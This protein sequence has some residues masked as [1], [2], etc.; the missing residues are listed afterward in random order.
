MAKHT[1][2]V[3]SSIAAVPVA[4]GL[5]AP[6]TN[7]ATGTA[8]GHTTRHV[9]RTT[10]APKEF[11][12]PMANLK[13]WTEAVVVTMNNVRIEGHSPVHPLNN[14]CEMHFGAH[15]TAFQG[16]PDGLVLEPMNVCVQPFPGQSA[17]NNSDWT[18]FGDQLVNATIS[19]TGV[20]RIWPEHLQGG[21]A[22][23]PDHAVEMHPLTAIANGSAN[24]DFTDNIFAG[25]YGGG[26]G[27]ATAFSILDT[28][29]VDVT[30]SG[31]ALTVSFFGGTIGNFTVLDVQIDRASITGDG[32]G[33][34]RMT[35]DVVTNDTTVPVR[36]VS[37][38]GTAMN[39]AIGKL[40]STS[41]A[42]V[43]LQALV[44]FSLSPEALLDAANKS[45]G[46]AQSVQTPIQLILY[47]T[48]D[49]K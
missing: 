14:D 45:N 20:P 32:A 31:A 18:T 28:A 22:S 26:V 47:G 8:A 30:R 42:K 1:R 44:L 33:S 34:F 11:S 3:T 24:T 23:N 4:L 35:G 15:S 41:S 40:R 39:D 43:S 17:Q 21:S 49:D 25:A 2:A 29:T 36:L 7:T 16:S 5:L 12:I 9:S 48:P 10:A 6:A 27:E 13:A 38:K 46:N 19:A 37:I